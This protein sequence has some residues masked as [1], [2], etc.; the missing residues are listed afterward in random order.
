MKIIRANECLMDAFEYDETR[1]G[2]RDES[3]HK[4]VDFQEKTRCFKAI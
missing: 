1:L 2:F 3:N 4:S